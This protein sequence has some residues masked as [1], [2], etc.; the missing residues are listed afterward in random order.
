MT[1]P[2]TQISTIQPRTHA[3]LW[4]V[5][6]IVLGFCLSFLAVA[7]NFW[8][9]PLSGDSLTSD[10]VPHLGS[11]Y[12][13]LTEGRYFLNPEHPPLAKDIAA[14]PLLFL[15]IRHPTIVESSAYTSIED[16]DI[17]L[18]SPYQF[19]RLLEL[20]NGSGLYG[21]QLLFS[22]GNDADLLALLG[23]GMICL[24]NCA[25]LFCLYW[26][27]RRLTGERIALLGLLLMTLS[28]FTLAH[29]P[30]IATDMMSSL[31]QLLTL[32]SFALYLQLLAKQGRSQS[33]FWWTVGWLA[34][35]LLTKF[36]SI[37]VIPVLFLGGLIF[38][39][40]SRGVRWSIRSFLWRFAL[41][42]VAS[43][44]LVVLVYAFHVRNSEAA[45]I[46]ILI[47][48]YY[49]LDFLPVGGSG[50]LKS[51]AA[52]GV[53][54]RGL[55][56]Y[57]IGLCMVLW[58]LDHPSQSTYFLGSLYQAE[59]AG[60]WYFP[61]LYLT[62]LPLGLLALNATAAG[63]GAYLLIQKKSR[64]LAGLFSNSFLLLL[65]AYVYLYGMVAIDQ[66]LNI[67]LRH[68]FPFI[69]GA[70]LLTA[71]A[72][73]ACH[74]VRIAGFTPF[75]IATGLAVSGMLA[76]SLL[77]FPGYLSTY[78]TF[79]GGREAGYQIATDSNYDWGQDIKRLARWVRDEPVGP[80]YAELFTPSDLEYY[81]G[82]RVIPYSILES[83]NLKPGD[84]VAVSVQVLQNN[85]YQTGLLSSQRY[86]HLDRRLVQ[87]IGDTIFVYQ[88][89]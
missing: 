1:K 84:Y 54:G 60:A 51:L 16:I 39:V 41:L 33:Q 43:A 17:A 87:R 45:E 12:Y 31:L 86:D 85:Q 58:R 73:T 67:G 68:L 52:A 62:K 24:T 25:L 77:S 53:L 22:M 57:L 28:P 34:A 49:N 88:V 4:A 32:A 23:R 50:L 82:D 37:A 7:G 48:R 35:A 20:E 15:N 30:L 3:T 2:T 71:Y 36:S 14:L 65:V 72:L 79:G 55:V 80:I 63:A 18:V 6:I 66:S 83:P 9:D 29:L 38:L 10:E 44:G 27:V 69:L 8:N 89:V 21:S 74:T 81:F 75:K 47:D 46:G 19:P 70:S 11:G 42:L 13:A 26:Y 56:Q 78:N 40:Q 5:V 76:A 59:G 61:V 64:A